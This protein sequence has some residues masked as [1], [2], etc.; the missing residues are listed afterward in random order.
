M[1][2]KKSMSGTVFHPQKLFN[3]YSNPIELKKDERIS[4]SYAWLAIIAS[5]LAY[6]I[7][8]VKTKKAETLTRAFW[9]STEQ[10]VKNLIP[11]TAW[12]VLSFHLLAEKKIRKTIFG[13]CKDLK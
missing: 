4:G 1:V 10:P 2:V 13:G 3:Y 6:D 7:Y 11:V 8:A 5:V 9:R 12:V